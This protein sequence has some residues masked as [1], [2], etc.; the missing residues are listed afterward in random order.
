LNQQIERRIFL[1]WKKIA[2]FL[3][4]IKNF[5]TTNTLSDN[6]ESSKAKQ[7]SEIE[8]DKIR[9]DAAVIVEKI[10]RRI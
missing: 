5:F 8:L 9:R 10:S 7:T 3:K 4:R 1:I 2:D 6:L